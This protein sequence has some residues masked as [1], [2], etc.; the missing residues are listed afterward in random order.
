MMARLRIVLIAGI[1]ACGGSAQ[2]ER[3]ASST[4]DKLETAAELE[5]GGQSEDTESPPSPE[6]NDT[7]LSPAHFERIFRELRDG[8][9]NEGLFAPA[10]TLHRISGSSATDVQEEHEEARGWD[11][12]LAMIERLQHSYRAECLQEEPPP[13]CKWHVGIDYL[14]EP[15][16]DAN[17][18]ETS[19]PQQ[20]GVPHL[21]RVCFDEQLRAN[22]ITI[23]TA[24]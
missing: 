8:I 9:S 6:N 7:S 23:D 5:P 22:T 10:M 16:C 12:V 20:P 13:D 21:R 17:C 4:G 2:V 3:S 18:C 19:K 1:C 15:S 14:G 24:R 11:L